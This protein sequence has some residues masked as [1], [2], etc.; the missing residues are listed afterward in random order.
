MK[1]KFKFNKISKHSLK[2]K[3]SKVA[4]LKMQSKSSTSSQ[5]QTKVFVK[6]SAKRKISPVQISNVPV[7]EKAKATATKEE[8]AEFS[9]VELPSPLAASEPVAFAPLD[10]SKFL[11][12]SDLFVPFDEREVAKQAGC[13][14][15]AE[16]RIWFAPRAQGFEDIIKQ[17]SG[18]F[19][20]IPAEDREEAKAM[21]ATFRPSTASWWGDEKMA[22]RWGMVYLPKATYNDKDRLKALKCKWCPFNRKWFTNKQSIAA[23]PY[24]FNVFL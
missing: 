3:S 22:Q 21:G 9:P 17:Y 11:N 7:Q 8:K 12:K 13:Y 2:L 14:W 4:K 20:D 5:G 23:N 10:M 18:E 24:A 1:L 15:W 6:T 16:D 19:L